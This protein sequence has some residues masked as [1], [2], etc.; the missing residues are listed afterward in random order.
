MSIDHVIILLLSFWSCW[1]HHSGLIRIWGFQPEPISVGQGN[2]PNQKQGGV[3]AHL[4]LTKGKTIPLPEFIIS[5]LNCESSGWVPKKHWSY[6]PVWLPAIRCSNKLHRLR[7]DFLIFL[8]RLKL[9]FEPFPDDKIPHLVFVRL[10]KLTFYWGLTGKTSPRFNEN[11]RNMWIVHSPI[12]RTWSRH[13]LISLSV[14]FSNL[15]WLSLFS[16]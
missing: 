11:I 6:R 13:S 5:I 12:P 14:I 7:Q 2:E 16:S 9:F 10:W 8:M 4:C 1:W 15:F 3:L